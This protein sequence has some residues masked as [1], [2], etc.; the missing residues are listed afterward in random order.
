MAKYTRKLV[1]LYAALLYNA[2]LKGFVEGE[3]YQGKIKSVCVPGLNCYSCPGAIGACP[4]G[5]LQNAL[6][7]S[8]HRA[9]WY[10]L[11]ILMLFGLT[12]GRTICGWIC[13]MGLIQ[14]LLHKIPG[15]KIRKS[16][17]TRVLSLLKYVILVVFVIAIPLWYGL[18]HN[19]PM[20]GFCK[21][22]CPAG[23]LEGAVGLLANEENS[24]LFA[25]LGLY[26]TRKWVILVILGLAC[27]FCYRAFCR[28][29]CPL[30]ALYGLF[31]RVALT[32]VRVEAGKCSGC[33]R[34]VRTCSMDVRRVGDRECIS[35]GK[36]MHH[37][38]GGAISLKCGKLTL[39]KAEEDTA[40]RR[41]RRLWGRIAWGIA[42]VFLAF[43]L[44]WVN[45]PGEERVPE[46]AVT[47]EDADPVP[48][49]YEKGQRLKNFEADLIGGGRFSLEAC[50]GRVVILNL[51]ATYCKPCITELPLFDQL[52]KKYPDVEILAIHEGTILG[53]ADVEAF[54]RDRDWDLKFTVDTT[55]GELFRLVNGSSTLPQTLVLDRDGKV[56]Y[57]EVRSVTMEMLEALVIEAGAEATEE[58]ILE[59]TDA[60]EGNGKGQRLPD[61]SM[62]L[63][64]GGTFHLRDY[65][66]RVVVLNL[67]A[68]YCKPCIAE[69]PYFDQLKKK[70]PEVEVLAVHDGT[71]MSAG[72]VSDFLKEYSWDLDFALDS[73]GKVFDLVDG[74]SKLPQT[75]V[76]DPRGIVLY[77]EIRSMTSEMLETLVLEA[78]GNTGEG[79]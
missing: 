11:G 47:A 3:I 58:K 74:S 63:L 41:K 46:T 8:G 61:F 64:K 6:N 9:P 37:C 72:E 19:L 65:R 34:C 27:I 42:V 32:G 73:D 75:L 44:V 50:R 17:V 69:L 78:L 38:P 13:P 53:E 21:Y 56:I 45:L 15:P 7:A 70:Y 59:A 77:N 5:A 43:V 22:I 25:T 76:L 52:K 57:N 12:L 1:Q 30:G 29:L 10:V 62:E 2:H 36:C 54:L 14:E 39:M 66:G 24:G 18:Q 28:F 48:E 31:N 20:P 40:E 49:G 26:F 79:G 71:I 33:G 55:E 68:T 67:W 4:L 35:C 16:R 23:T 60:E 51:W